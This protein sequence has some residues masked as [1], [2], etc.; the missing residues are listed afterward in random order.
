MRSSTLPSTFRRGAGLFCAA[1]LLQVAL[2]TAVSAGAAES[3]RKSRKP[4]LAPEVVELQRAALAGGGAAELARS[5]SGE[6]GPRFAG[7]PGLARGVEWGVRTLTAL[8][9]EGVRTEAVRVPRWERGTAEG[10][11]LS[12]FPHASS[13]A[14]LG[15]SIGT[16][17][18]GIEA[19]V[20][21]TEN[22]ESLAA[23]AP[24]SVK[25][26]IVYLGERMQRSHDGS[27]Y[28]KTVAIRWGGAMAA[29]KLGAVAV[30]I[31]SVGTDSNRLPHTGSM[32][33][34]EGVT[35]IPA[36]AL[37]MPDADLLEQA[38]ASGR[39]VR[40]RLRL[41]SRMLPEVESANVI[42]E[43]RGRE[44]PEEVVI[45]S[46]HLDSW[47]LGTGALDDAAGIGNVIEAARLISKLASRPRRTIRI[48]L[49]ANEE[50]G[51]SGGKTY[52]VEHA[53][54]VPLHQAAL[55]SDLGTGRVY[56]LRTAFAAQDAALAGELAAALAP[57]G[58]EHDPATPAS[59]G[60]DISPLRPLGVPM[61]DLSHDATTYFD[62]HHTANDTADKLVPADMAQATAAFATAA[63]I[64]ADRP[65]LL[66]RVPPEE[67]KE[68]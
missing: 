54:E 18:S 20:V 3:G 47:D 2:A 42:G 14:A 16:P 25:G 60:A 21:A 67:K 15:G 29:A 11:I 46:G 58:I 28:G 24:E 48:V 34:E 6:A 55:E 7:S 43:L 64:L 52:A 49:Y 30:L 13:L 44:R 23:L 45:L 10:E 62:Y 8:G 61:V 27:G 38:V 66:A 36:A 4:Q 68:P 17:E 56:R 40:F 41:T 35:K 53:A 65:A 33:Y 5:L 57:L 59:G 9:F 51:L 37:S 31:R 63:W 19:E 39:P 32:G 26:R 1:A 12:P 22:L 50:F